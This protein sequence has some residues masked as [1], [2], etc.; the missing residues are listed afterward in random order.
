MKK[1]IFSIEGRRFEIE[2]ENDFADFVEAN[3]KEQEID[4]DRSNEVL[5]FI[6][7]YLSLL[8]ENYE[9]REHI[10]T[11]LNKLDASN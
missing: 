6:K 2:L 8:K 5:E 7:A 3:L 11:I 9:A 10:K 1:V 4:Q